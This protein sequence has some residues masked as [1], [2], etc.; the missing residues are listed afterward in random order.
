MKAPSLRYS[1]KLEGLCGNCN[2]DKEDDA[3]GPN[4]EPILDVEEF[5]LSWLY[6]KLPGGQTRE[7]CLNVQEEICEPLPPESDPCAQLVDISKYGQVS[8]V[9]CLRLSELHHLQTARRVC[10]CFYHIAP[11]LERCYIYTCARVEVRYNQSLLVHVHVPFQCHPV[12]DPM[13][14]IDW[15]RKDT[16]NDKPEQACNAISAY[17]RECGTLGFCMDWRTELCPAKECPAGLEYKSCS[18]ACA[19]TCEAVTKGDKCQNPPVEGC[20]CP[21]NKVIYF[22]GRNNRIF[23]QNSTP[24]SSTSSCTSQISHA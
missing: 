13:L 3:N 20:F 7:Q 22:Y 17:S 23:S 14:F 18:P 8:F 9:N 21:G 12:L 2:G 19:R 5:G 15:C 10:N 11:Q 16:C 1:G 6:D 4:G 24:W